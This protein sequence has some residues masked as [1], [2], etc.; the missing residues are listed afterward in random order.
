M[1]LFAVTTSLC[2]LAACGGKSES[3]QSAAA[4]TGNQSSFE[5]GVRRSYRAKFIESCSTGA[6]QAAAKAGNTAATGIN[7][8]PLCGCAA[9]KL[10]ATK[11]MTELMVGPSQA[12]QLAVT[13]QC[14][15]EHP[16][17]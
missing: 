9:D 12:D 16:L 17:A 4:A 1:R 13:Q 6:K 3:N 7:Y 15:K 5:S 11:S 14:L 8:A 2:L 10:L